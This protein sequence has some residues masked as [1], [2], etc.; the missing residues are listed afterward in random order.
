MSSIFTKIINGEIPCYKIAEDEN[1]LAFLDVNPNA[2]GHT[3]CIPKQEINKIFEMEDDLYIGLMQFSKKIAVALEK[4]VPCKRI[5]MAV[6]GLEVPHAHVHLIPLN[7][8]DEMR[9]Q[10]KVSLSKDEFEALAESIKTNL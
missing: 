6:V 1:F 4:T 5:G 9:F 7:E 2:K 10:N 3:L 8:M